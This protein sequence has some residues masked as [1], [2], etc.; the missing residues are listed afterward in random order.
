MTIRHP[1]PMFMA[2][3]SYDTYLYKFSS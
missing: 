2:H 3:C 1:D